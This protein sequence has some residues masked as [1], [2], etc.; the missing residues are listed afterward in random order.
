MIF[1]PFVKSPRAVGTGGAGWGL[2]APPLDVL[3]FIQTEAAPVLFQIHLR[4]RLSS[5]VRHNRAAVE[6]KIA[7]QTV[8]TCEASLIGG[9]H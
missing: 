1:A 4:S 9:R 2:S 8:L 5:L 7:G 6:N 3:A